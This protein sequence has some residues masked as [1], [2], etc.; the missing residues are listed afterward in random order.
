MLYFGEHLPDI[1]ST[2]N[3]LKSGYA[4]NQTIK[5]KVFFLHIFASNFLIQ[6]LIVIYHGNLN[7]SSNV[8]VYTNGRYRSRKSDGIGVRRIRTFPFSSDSTLLRL[9]RLCSAD[10]LVKTRLSELDAEVEGLC[11]PITSTF[12]RFVLGLVLPPLL[13]TPTT[14][15]VFT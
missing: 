9:R 12:Q 10:D 3:H 6:V 7:T 15:A 13:V 2:L 11:K 1:F 5:K 4:L 8:S 14:D